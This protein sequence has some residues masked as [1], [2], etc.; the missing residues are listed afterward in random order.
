MR[1]A[2]KSLVEKPQGNTPLGRYRNTGENN[3]KMD[4][5]EMGYEVD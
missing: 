3:I 2:Y 1:N 4:I 5:S